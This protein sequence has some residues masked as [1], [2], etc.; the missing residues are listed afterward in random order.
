MRIRHY[1]HGKNNPQLVLALKKLKLTVKEKTIGSVGKNP[2][3]H[4][5]NCL[6]DDDHSLWPE[7]RQL[8]EELAI[9]IETGIEYSRQD[10]LA[11][12]WCLVNAIG[13]LDYPQ[14][15]K[16]FGYRSLTFDLTSYCPRCGIGRIQDRPYRLKP[17]KQPKRYHFFSPG[18]DH[19]S[20]FCTTEV[21]SL[22]QENRVSGTKF[23]HPVQNGNG[24]EIPFL[25]QIFPA[26]ELPS[27]I[28][29]LG[30]FAV[31]CEPNNQ[32]RWEPPASA[33]WN[34]R[35]PYCGRTKYHVPYRT[36]LVH[37]KKET[38][39][40]AEDVVLSHEWFGS[41]GHAMQQVIVS[42]KFVSIAL[43]KGLKGLEFSPVFYM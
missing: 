27:G 24:S 41:G 29:P 39:A 25:V 40:N 20:L 14:P 32:E 15:E 16:N 21:Q 38:F 31:D 4:Y 22:L 2:P 43:D 34:Q 23:I 26:R 12:D 9:R 19:Q 18:W 36:R 8:C 17:Q 13:S 6:I 37:Y 30:Q 1:I 7:V 5:F 42:R 35:P 11:A 28:I 10:I 33:F 3:S